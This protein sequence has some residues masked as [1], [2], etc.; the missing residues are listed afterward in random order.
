MRGLAAVL[1]VVV[2]LNRAVQQAERG[3]QDARFEAGEVVGK[4]LNPILSDAT[5]A[6]LVD[7]ASRRETRGRPGNETAGA[8]IVSGA[9]SE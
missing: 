8:S 5:T 7:S 6:R 4:Q 1:D 9:K 2:L 3:G